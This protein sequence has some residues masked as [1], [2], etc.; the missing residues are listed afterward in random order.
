MY[1]VLQNTYGA[2][3]R[4][5]TGLEVQFGLSVLKLHCVTLLVYS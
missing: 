4:L 2:G 3:L 1:V 5:G